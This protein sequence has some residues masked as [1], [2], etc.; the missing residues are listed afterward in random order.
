MKYPTPIPA[1]G[2]LPEEL[3]VAM[4]ALWSDSGVQETFKRAYEYQLNDSA[5]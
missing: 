5:P 2:C 3:V 1:G 4:K